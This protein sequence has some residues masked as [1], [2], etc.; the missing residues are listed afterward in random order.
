MGNL[1][2]F[3]ENLSIFFHAKDFTSGKRFC[4]HVLHRAQAH[5]SGFHL[6]GDD[7]H[8]LR[9]AGNDSEKDFS[10]KLFYA[11]AHPE[12]LEW[13]VEGDRRIIH[14]KKSVIT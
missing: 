2:E 4:C 11:N 1:K 9:R 7:S 12:S 14:L 13:G 10:T 5:C 8:R 3:S 6:L